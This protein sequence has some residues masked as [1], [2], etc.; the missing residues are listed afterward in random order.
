MVAV[1]LED[2]PV[3]EVLQLRERLA[4]T[5]DET[6]GVV[7]LNVQEYAF[8][9]FLFLDACLEAEQA[10]ELFRDRFGI[11]FHVSCPREIRETPGGP[12]VN[13]SSAVPVYRFGRASPAPLP[14]LLPEL[15]P[16]DAAGRSSSVS[17]AGCSADC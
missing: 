2:D 14:P 5:T 10:Q 6:S 15:W 4:L 17:S 8:F 1:L 11:C 9:S 3:N 12:S 13:S 7:A 16:V